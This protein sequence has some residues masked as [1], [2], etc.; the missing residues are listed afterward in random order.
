MHGVKYLEERFLDQG[1]IKRSTSIF[2]TFTWL[3]GSALEDYGVNEVVALAEHFKNNFYR[4]TRMKI[5]CKLSIMSGM[6][7]NSSVLSEM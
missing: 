2:D 4:Q 3:T 1:D 5:V 6:N 7:L